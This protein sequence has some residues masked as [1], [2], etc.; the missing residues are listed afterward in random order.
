MHL[1]SR[2]DSVAKWQPSEPGWLSIVMSTYVCLSVCA[3]VCLS[4]REHISG[5]TCAIFTKFFAHVAYGRGSVLLQQGDEI[6]NGMGNFEGF[7][8]HQQYTV[9]HSLQKGSFNIGWEGGDGSAQ[10][11]RSML[12][13]IALLHFA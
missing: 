12:S 1:R 6:P 7:P 9:S 3:S 10:R 2:R 13:T 4:V 5:T 11:G 8:P